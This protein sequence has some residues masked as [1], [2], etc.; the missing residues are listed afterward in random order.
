MTDYFRPISQTDPTVPRDALP[1]AGGWCWFNMVEVM[2]R[3]TPPERLPA[4]DVP[5]Q[6]LDDLTSPRTP[7][8]GLSWNAPRLMG[9]LNATPDSFSDGGCF[10]DPED[11]MR[12]ARQLTAEGADILD[13]GGESTRPGAETIDVRRE[14]SRVRPVI[15]A[16]GKAG[17][18]P[19]VSIDTRKSAVARA[20][21]SAGAALINDVAA[22][23]FDPWLGRLAA[24]TG[25]PVCLMH[26]QGDPKTMQ[27][28]PTYD[29]VVLDVFDF[30]T[31]RIKAAEAAGVSRN[32][33]LVD[34]GIG[35]G[36]THVHNLE[37]L[38]RVSLFHGLGCPLLLG[39]SRK[40]F[41]GKIGG[42]RTVGERMPGS[43]SISLH[44]AAQGVQLH[45]V[46]DIAPHKQALRLWEALRG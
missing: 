3:H 14:I 39:A 35:F 18:L 21:V 19:P 2:R 8:A 30:L 34:P 7:L 23:T 43:V 29:H 33:I 1:L 17:D 10:L 4:A 27:R 38:K 5:T 11:A 28:N 25:T 13:I 41:I 15:E 40:S 24:E 32:A 37:L 44:A 42:T 31:D 12:H 22:M 9:I 26:A 20:A 6:V 45:R 16:I 46:H 36:K